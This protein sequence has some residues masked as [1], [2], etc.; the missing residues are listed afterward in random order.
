VS[1]GGGLAENGRD[2]IW[3]DLVS[4]KEGYGA[5]VLSLLFSLDLE[6]DGVAV[7]SF[8]DDA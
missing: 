5:V 1:L 2:C 6:A 3:D 7:G 4:V 8:E